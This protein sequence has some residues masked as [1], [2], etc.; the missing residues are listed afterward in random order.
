ML[1]SDNGNLIFET[2]TNI[3]IRSNSTDAGLPIATT[4]DIADLSIQV[5]AMMAIL[6]TQTSTQAAAVSNQAAANLDAL[7]TGVSASVSASRDALSASVAASLQRSIGDVST[8]LNTLSVAV[9]SLDDRITAATTRTNQLSAGVRS[10]STATAASVRTMG[11]AL[12]TKKD[13]LVPQ[14]IGGAKDWGR[15]GSWRAFKL[16]R[17]D[18][19]SCTGIGACRKNGADTI[20]VRRPGMWQMSFWAISLGNDYTRSYFRRLT[21]SG[22]SWRQITHAY[23]QGTRN[24]KWRNQRPHQ[25]ND[26][27]MIQEYK[28]IVGDRVQTMLHNT[29]SRGHR[30]HHGNYNTANDGTY[31]RF[32]FKFTG[33]AGAKC[34]GCYW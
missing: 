15:A 21:N 3:L 14:W 31:N 19:D 16:D 18:Y 4:A 7:S 20:E 1:L 23:H 27:A 9:G 26:Q 24:D 29:K 17:V 33:R 30:W 11:L 34:R 13:D 6:S 12:A 2:E 25:W 10:Q 22:R 28:F 32:Y 8:S 5:S